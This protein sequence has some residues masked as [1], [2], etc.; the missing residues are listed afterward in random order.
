M[1]WVI[2]AIETAAGCA[3]MMWDRPGATQADFN[4]DNYACE[5]DARQSGYYGAGLT[6]TVNMQDFF[7]RRMEAQGHA[8]R[9]SATNSSTPTGSSENSSLPQ[10]DAECLVRFGGLQLAGPTLAQPWTAAFCALSARLLEYSSA[11]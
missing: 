4:R 3:P 5:R 6:G 11:L 10:N 9:S 2:V 7:R 1:R 8:L